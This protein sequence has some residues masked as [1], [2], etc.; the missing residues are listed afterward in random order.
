MAGC[1]RY[2]CSRTEVVDTFA[3]WRRNHWGFR[4]LSSRGIGSYSSCSSLSYAI[5]RHWLCLSGFA[6]AG[7]FP[8]QDVQRPPATCQQRECHFA[9]LGCNRR[10]R[11]DRLH[12]HSGDE[13]WSHCSQDRHRSPPLTAQPGRSLE[14]RGNVV[15][16][17][18][19]QA[20][21]LTMQSLLT[22]STNPYSN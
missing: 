21:K 12:D 18:Y 8:L 16:S 4:C 10:G 3:W 6:D 9:A 15:S 14:W 19:V 7:S 22:L 2:D 13:F 1:H 11:H 17:I 20:M 5:R